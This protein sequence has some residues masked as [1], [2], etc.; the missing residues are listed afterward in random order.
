VI[1]LTG[2]T[3][4]SPR[5]ARG[6]RARGGFSLL[7]VAIV[8]VILALVA[9]I[10]IPRLS[11]GS[12]GSVE[13]ALAR[14]IQVMQKAIDLYA[15][16]HNGAFPDPAMIADQLTLYTDHS[17]ASAKGKTSRYSYGP[18]LRK[19]PAV[20]SGPNT[21]SSNISTAPGIG[22]GWIYDPAEGTIAPNN[23]A[24]PTSATTQS[25]N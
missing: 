7:E 10:A 11:R 1:V 6:R 9:A 16:D 23:T 17:G 14:D 4:P 19:I 2:P 25:N 20:P 12:Q 8:I 18:Y 13:A 22:V 24:P 5:A 21:G 15:A 3:P